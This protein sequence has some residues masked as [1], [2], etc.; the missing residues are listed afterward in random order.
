MSRLLCLLTILLLGAAPQPSPND[1]IGVWSAQR[2]F[3]PKIQSSAQVVR[4]GFFIQPQS[5]SG[6][7]PFAI[8]QRF[9]STL[10]DTQH[11]YFVVQR[12]TDGTLEAFFRN[13]ES[14]AGAGIGTRSV[15][16]AGAD[17]HL[18][19]ANAPDLT[20]SLDQAG[21]LHFQFRWFPGDF[22]FQ[23]GADP[24]FY[25]RAG[26]TNYQ[27]RKPAALADGW[28]TASLSAVGLA[29]KPIVDLVNSIVHAS[30]D[31]LRAPYIQSLQIERHGRLV[32][33]EYFYGFD[34][35]RPHD[36]RSA[37]KSVTTLMI[38][39][40]IQDHAPV[41]PS[42]P[43]LRLFSQYAPIA[44]D[45]SRKQHM[46]VAHLMTMSS[47]FACD[48]NDDT[49]PG[50]EDAMQS[51]SKQPDWYK[52]TLDLPMLYEPG[53]RS[54]YCSA[55]I[56]LLGGILT[57]VTGKWLPAYFDQ[58]FAR[59]M[60]FGTYGL[61]L[62]S[63]PPETAYMAGG[64][65]FR[66]RD[67]LKFGQLFL[68]HGRWNGRPIISDEWLKQSAI[69]RTSPEGEGDQYGYGW[70]LF[71]YHAGSKTIHAISAGGNGG[72]LLVILPQLDMAVMMTAGNYG[73][74]PV[75]RTYAQDLIPRYVVSAAVK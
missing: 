23:K 46:T 21:A 25:P 50:N 68:D 14:N 54:I 42:S 13:P 45:D 17:V 39:R 66:P 64:D 72:Q 67:F 40:A 1:L 35:G 62:M 7:A 27:Y 34:A 33:D 56:N 49:S 52:Y 53:M 74:F 51:Q 63:P 60:Q 5:E 16:L 11:F 10:R 36:M 43:V 30:T 65:Y 69:P 29:P 15:V 3:G 26:V 61:W 9:R 57:R 32:L 18:Q 47:G 59:P 55:G 75:W 2:D 70:H 19:R 41:S 71:D 24:V 38:G 4:S 22:V 48:D 20:G 28:H 37:S 58:H 73:Q 12:R 6:T 31:S 44:N 8:P